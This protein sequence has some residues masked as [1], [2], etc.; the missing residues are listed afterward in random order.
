M[1]E[2]PADPALPL[3]LDGVA[4]P[5]LAPV[6]MVTVGLLPPVVVVPGK[7]DVDVVDVG[8]LVVETPVAGCPG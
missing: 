2:L 1:S 8:A 7:L 6:E 4:L 3:A 5:A